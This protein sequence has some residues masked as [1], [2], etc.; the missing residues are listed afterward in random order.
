[1]LH[2]ICPVCG[3]EIK[4]TNGGCECGSGH[5]FDRAK[6]GYFNLLLSNCKNSKDPGDNKE[7]VKARHEFLELGLYAPL[8]DK[9][10]DIITADRPFSQTILDAGTGTGFYIGYISEKRKQYNDIFLG[11]DISKNAVKIAAKKNKNVECTVSSVY[12]LPYPDKSADIITCIFSPYAMN[13]YMRVLKDD[14][15]L[16]LVSPRENHLIELRNLLYAEVRPLETIVPTE[17]FALFKEENLSYNF[18]LTK[19]ND[20][21]NL[22]T[23]TPYVYRAPAKNV[24]IV[25]KSASLELTADFKI[26]LLTKCAIDHK[27]N[28]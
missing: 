1:M 10:T 27:L 25:K 5:T 24:D 15:L 28:Y 13:E 11:T 17:G 23:M 16:I 12:S 9:V 8:A 18:I 26:T 7:M 6:E 14:G 20:I 2:F 21:A 4:E 3:A 22:L 19:S